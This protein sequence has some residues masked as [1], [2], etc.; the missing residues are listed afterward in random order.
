MFNKSTF[1]YKYCCFVEKLTRNIYLLFS[2]YVMI[3]KVITEEMKMENIN[4]RSID[5]I[6]NQPQ[7]NKKELGF[8]GRLI[9][10][11]WGQKREE[12]E[13][14]LADAIMELHKSPPGSEINLL[15]RDITNC[16]AKTYRHSSDAVNFI[17]E[18]YV[19]GADHKETVTSV[20]HRSENGEHS[21]IFSETPR[22]D[23]G[24]YPVSTAMVTYKT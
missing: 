2:N 22:Q 1:I 8:L 19:I 9:A 5:E 17:L 20:T 24:G 7:T 14:T 10:K 23:R 3:V 18:R 11:F 12:K 16:F 21:M 13:L 4:K 15:Y 6:L